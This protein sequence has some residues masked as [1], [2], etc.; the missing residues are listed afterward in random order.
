MSM[1]DEILASYAKVSAALAAD[2][3]GAAKKA[4]AEV[5]EHAGMAGNIDLAGKASAVAQAGKIDAA[6]GAFKGLSAAAEPL[7]KG[8]K[9]YVV[10][11]CPMAGDWVQTKG[12]T[13]NP[14]MGKAML[15][16]G[17]PKEMK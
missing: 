11:H 9:D 2:D 7:A 10:M 17:G 12:P 4:A 1:K 6:R 16:C 3:L 5:A 13:K 8:E 14:Y 15:S